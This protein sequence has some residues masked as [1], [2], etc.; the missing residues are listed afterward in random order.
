M[1]DVSFLLIILVLANDR[2]ERAVKF[3]E[4]YSAILTRDESLK[5]ALFHVVTEH[6]KRFPNANKLKLLFYVC[7]STS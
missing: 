6:W 5:Q 3:I 1:G 2:A 7:T 4:N